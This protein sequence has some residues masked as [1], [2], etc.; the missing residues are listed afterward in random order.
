M[1]GLVPDAKAP[2]ES[3]SE[4]RSMT[5]IPSTFL[6][7]LY[8]FLNN[9][10]LP[11]TIAWDAD[12]RSFS[13]LDPEKMESSLPMPALYRGRFKTF[14]MQLEKHGFMKSRDGTR[15]FRPDFVKGQ[16]QQLGD[17]ASHASPRDTGEKR[18]SLECRIQVPRVHEAALLGHKKRRLTDDAAEVHTA[19]VSWPGKKS[20]SSLLCS[21]NIAK[22]RHSPSPS[23]LSHASGHLSFASRETAVRG[24]AAMVQSQHHALLPEAAVPC[25]DAGLVPSLR[26]PAPQSHLPRLPSLHRAFPRFGLQFQRP[27]DV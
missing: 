1:D 16:P 26:P 25:H 12:G 2:T 3:D 22:P 17:V 5:A 7:N 4:E 23:H 8:G 9:N 13:I 14:K 27:G 10:N 15:Y 18:L 21:V 20:A 11:D 6:R 24:S 19:S